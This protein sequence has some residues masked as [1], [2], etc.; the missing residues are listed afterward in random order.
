MAPFPNYRAAFVEA[1]IRWNAGDLDGLM[2]LCHDDIVHTVNIDGIGYAASATGK[3]ELRGRLQLLL[4]TF[5]VN[6]FVPD[7]IWHGPDYSR[8]LVLGYYKHRKTG[9]RLDIKVRFNCWVRDGFIVRMEEHHDAAYV[10]AFH[11]F[12]SHLEA[13]AREQQSAAAV[14]P[15][16]P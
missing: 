7:N 8:S 3:S 13:T 11:R 4:D 5:E 6:A 15:G 10:G 9:E 12:V 14:R 1:H 2:D 16:A